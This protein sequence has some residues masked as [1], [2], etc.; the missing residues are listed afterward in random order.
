MSGNADS[1]VTSQAS[2]VSLPVT[3]RAVDEGDV[4][5]EPVEEVVVALADAGTPHL[6]W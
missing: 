5:A 2:R 6:P 4:A 1:G 3:P